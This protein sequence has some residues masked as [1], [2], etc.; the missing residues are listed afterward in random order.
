MSN[1]V[2]PQSSGRTLLSYQRIK[3]NILNETSHLRRYDNKMR[4]SSFLHKNRLNHDQLNAN[5]PRPLRASKVKKPSLP[6]RQ[7][8]IQEAFSRIENKKF[9]N[10]GNLEIA[11]QYD[12]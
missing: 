3:T 2:L 9:T 12:L 4:R 7:I 10:D 5:I 8:L 1:I 11:N 6:K